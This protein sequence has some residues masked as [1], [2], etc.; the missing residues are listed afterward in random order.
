[1][2]ITT[3]DE[4]SALIAID[5]QKGTLAG[6]AP[7][8]GAELLATSRRLIDAFRDR[9][10]PVVLVNVTGGAPGRTDAG[11]GAPRP[12][13]WTELMPELGDHPDDVLVTKTV[14][15]AFVGTDLDERLRAQGATQ[16]VVIGVSTSIGVESTARD[17]Y[18][19]GYHVSIATDAVADFRDDVA[20]NSIANI[21]PRL[22][23]TG[24]ADDIIAAL[25]ARSL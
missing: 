3:L 15:S 21:F 8:R 6:V 4:R 7:D 10:L 25:D 14:W 17:A 5:L 12:E 22:A 23:E 11:P 18:A 19:L 16:V 13:G 2:P 24:T 1:M 9:C 20:A